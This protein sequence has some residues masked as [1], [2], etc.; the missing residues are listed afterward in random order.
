MKATDIL[1]AFI[2]ILIVLMIII[3][4]PA[5]ILDVLL[6][7]NI[8]LSILILLI[9]MYAKDA[10]EISSFPS[11]LLVTTIFRLSL[12][13]STTRGILAKGYAGKV[14]ETFG[15]FVI[16]GD[17]VVGFIIFLII[18]I[19]NFMVITKGSERVSEVAARFTLDAMPGKQMAIDA[20][21]NTGLITDTEAKQ[22]RKDVQRS[23]D[24]YG[25]MDGAS[26]FVKGDSIASIIITFINIIGG[27]LIAVVRNDMDITQALQT[28]VLLTVGDG[29]VGQ[30]PALMISIATGMIVT[31]SASES[32]LSRDIMQQ[33]FGTETTVLFMVS[34]IIFGLAFTPLPMLPNIL[35][36]IFL[37]VVAMRRRSLL[38]EVP[39]GEDSSEIM[40]ESQEMKRPENVM[41]LL[42]ME[43]IELEFGYGLIPLADQDQGGDLLDRII[44]IRRQIA[45][46]LG[47]VVPV[48]RL[49]DNIQLSP[50][51]YAI[52]IKGV[53]VSRGEVLFDHFLAMD[54]G[55]GDGEIDGIDTI[56]PAFGLPAKWIS[57]SE[58]EKA[59]I[60]GYT[61]VDPPSVIATHLTEII[62]QKSYE[63]LGKQET[64]ELMENIREDYP[65]V[66]DDLVPNILSLGEVQKVLSNLL[67]EQVSIRD[68]VTILE[69]LSEYARITNDM[70]L[71]TE[72]VRQRLSGYITNKYV[73]DNKLQ[74]IVLDGHLEELI[75]NSLT[76]N[77]MGSYVAMEPDMV[78]SVLTNSLKEIQ[79]LTSIGEQPIVLTAPIVRLYFKRMT[80]QLT[81][82]MIV[83]SYNEIEPTVEV[84]SLGVISIE[85]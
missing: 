68:L 61:V 46:E 83:L 66:L 70:D 15:E 62:K 57:E 48:I 36:A 44:M 35:I 56:E 71:L 16:G 54:S 76:K 22:R 58:R 47:L 72:Y 5:A 59:E 31:R 64:K 2:I 8:A 49:R 18:V 60:F 29:L 80:E 78:Q 84:Q 9:S 21:L 77:E 28:Y 32:S 39:L 14:I 75:M 53:T 25:S 1:I 73:R 34:A 37:F 19:I 45:V 17:A 3:P 40:K 63:L 30:I 42:K 43:E 33:V 41:A 82:D 23:A 4:V 52:K 79:K 26:K 13:V 67:R 11:I 55:T 10:L 81:R 69:T 12:N 51:E 6:S 24:F 38:K 27:I 85:N 65:A 74:V 20:D 7:A 50:N